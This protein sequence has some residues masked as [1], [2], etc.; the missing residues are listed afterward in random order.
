MSA[1]LRAI[2]DA[3]AFL[4][5]LPLPC[6]VSA[7][8]PSER[9]VRAL[10]WFPL[11]GALIGA[12][13]GGVAWCAWQ[14][15]SQAI[16]AWAGIAALALLTG[17]L[18]LDGFAD[19]LDGLGAWKDREETLRIMQDSRVGAMGAVGLVILL[20]M[21]WSLLREFSPEFWVRTL[22]A[23]GA[24]S[25]LA[26]VLSAQAFPYVPNKQGL[27][28][29]VTE[30]RSPQAVLIA[31]VT[32]LGIAAAGLGLRRAG[33]LLAAT[34]ATTWLVNRFFVRRFGG[35]TGD[36]LGAVNELAGLSLFMVLAVSG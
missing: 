20:G 32:A 35:I 19:T 21:Q 1:W 18:H 9:M 10:A 15:W 13:A 24:M 6:P 23:L 34:A 27:G 25:R 29:L 5:I 30:G 8:R 7:D 36:T 33:T 3:L 26:M 2:P 16:G 11:A 17:G 28:R 12:A 4:T 14:L 31:V 22:A